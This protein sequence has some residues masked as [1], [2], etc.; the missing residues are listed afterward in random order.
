MNAHYTVADLDA[1]LAS[2]PL[3]QGDTL[4]LHSNIGFFGRPS[5][6]RDSGTLCEMFFDALMR[7]IGSRGTV[8]VPT[9][10]Y[11]FQR[12]RVFNPDATTSEMGLFSEWIRAHVD[13]K[14]SCDPSYSVAS[15]GDK[16]QLL[17]K[18][19]PENSFSHEG[20]FGRFL[21]ENGVV[22]N[23][24]FDAGSTFLHDLE[25]ELNVSYR[26]DK[27]FE[28]FIEQGGNKRFCKNT[29]YVRYMS[30][31]ST[32]AAFES[33]SNLAIERGCFHTGSLGRGQIGAIR[34]AD[35]KSLLVTT[36]PDR[37]WM[38]TKAEANGV[39]P[40]LVP[41]PVYQST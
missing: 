35:C 24:N 15:I 23:L 25:R 7:R 10:T 9:F 18:N 21:E 29:I 33:F 38:L 14:R 34:A 39:T 22:L 27:T 6:I 4:F 32:A 30:D 40:K 12:N 37:P 17:T 16:A 19:M 2:L 8:V 5:G 13:A 41:E 36:L 28:G 31:D 11:S 20:F 1:A 3:K 26:F